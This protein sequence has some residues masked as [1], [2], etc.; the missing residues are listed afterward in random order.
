[1]EKGNNPFYPVKLSLFAEKKIKFVGNTEL[2]RG[3]PHDLDG[4]P[5]QRVKNYKSAI[6]WVA[7]GHP[8]FMNPFKCGKSFLDKLL[9]IRFG[10]I[11]PNQTLNT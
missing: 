6:F 3:D 1:M 10:T 11:D 9:T 8:N 2:H 5:L 4:R 7:S